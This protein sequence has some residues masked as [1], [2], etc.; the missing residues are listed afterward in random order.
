MEEAFLAGAGFS[1]TELQ[2]TVRG[3]VAALFSLWAIWIIYNQFKL[4][5]TEQL[6]VIQWVFNSV[7]TVVILTMVLTLVST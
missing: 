2:H 7:T 1:A 3:L 5:V 4:V 6:T